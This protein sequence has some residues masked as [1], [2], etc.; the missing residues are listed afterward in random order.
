MSERTAAERTLTSPRYSNFQLTA[1][2]ILRML[3]GWHFFY[4]GLSKLVSPYW[5]SAGFLSESKWLFS[6]LFLWVAANPTPLVM[7]DFINK[8]GLLLIG[9]GLLLGCLTRAATY[10]GIALLFLYYIAAPPFAGYAYAMPAEGSYLI[11]NK[12]LIELAALLVL[13]AF[14]TGK[15]IGL[16]RLIFWKRE[17]GKLARLAEAAR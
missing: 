3:V 12:V 2:V 7:V 14:P 10:G 1:L 6:K 15:I 8:W 13:L 11:V 16:D 9:L 5:T 4:E 17:T